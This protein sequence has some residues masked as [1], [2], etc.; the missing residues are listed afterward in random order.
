MENEILLNY[1]IKFLNDTDKLFD[2]G[3]LERFINQHIQ[4]NLPSNQPEPCFNWT[5][6]LDADGYGHI[7]VNGKKIKAHRYAYIF[8]TRIAV[9]SDVMICHLCDNP[10][11]VNPK[12]LV[13]GNCTENNHD[14]IKK[15]RANFSGGKK[16]T[17]EQVYDIRKNKLTL[18]QSIDKYGHILCRRSLKYVRSGDT[19]GHVK[20]D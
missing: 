11:C 18:Q 19:Y 12:H 4:S 8:S 6:H 1:G 14:K 10:S 16:L 2:A 20:V 3:V 17:D 7:F 5:G 15:G 9:P 13:P